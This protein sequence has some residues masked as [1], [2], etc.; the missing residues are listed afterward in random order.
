MKVL[1]GAQRKAFLIFFAS[2]IPIT[3]F[4]DG[5]A[6][7][8]TFFPQFL[9][10]LIEWYCDLF[11][12]VLMRYPSPPWF[13]AVVASELILQVPFFFVAC[14]ML[15]QRET[16]KLERYPRWFQTLCIIYGSSVSTTLVPIL[17]S[18]WTSDTMTPAQ[19][20]ITTAI[21]SPYLLFPLALL[22]LAARDDFSE[23]FKPVITK[24]D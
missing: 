24:L 23:V 10:D 7:L 17:P 16:T 9:R 4:V 6:L 19:I 5:Q 3:L 21:Y 13:K 15:T 2:H 8:S 20:A 11:G 1:R 14:H 22:Y 12:D 18:F